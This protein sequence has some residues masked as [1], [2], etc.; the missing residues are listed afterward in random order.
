MREGRQ[1]LLG[2]KT[3]MLML[4]CFTAQAQVTGRLTDAAGRPVGFASVVLL[5]DADSTIVRSALSDEQGVFKL[6][7]DDGTYLLKISSLGCQPFRQPLDL[8]GLYDA[9]TI[10]LKAAEHQLGE[11][12]IR[13][14]KPLV[15]QQAGGLVV[16]VQNSLLTKGSTALEVLKRSPGV[17][18]DPQSTNITLN[19]KSG[20]MVMMDGKLL[21]L[22]LAQVMALLNG[23]NAD[24]I[25][26]IEL[27]N[28]P[29][30]RYDADGNAGLINIV[31]R[32]NKKPGTSGSV[33][34]SAGY[35]R[36]EKGSA[37]ISLDHN[38]GKVK[39]HSSYSYNHDRSYGLLLASGTENV[40]IIGGPTTFTYHGEGK[41]LNNYHGFSGGLEIKPGAKTTIGTNVYYS[42]SRDQNNA[43]N[44]GNYALADSNLAF[45]SH[46]AVN[47]TS[48]YLYGSMYLEHA[49]HKD[50]KLNIDVD[51]INRQ[52]SS[53]TQVE[54]NF[55]DSL[56]APR[57]RN[58]ANTDIRVGVIRIDQTDQLSKHLRL[59]AGVKGTYTKS[60]SNSGIENLVNGHW[61]YVGTGTSNN[62]GTNEFIAAAY[63]ILNV[64]LD[65]LTNLSAGGRYEHSQNTTDHSLNSQYAVNRRLGRFF[66]SVFVTRKFK[67][68]HEL[69]LSFTERIARPSYA[70]LAS[71]ITYNDPVSVFTGNPALKPTVTYNLKLGYSVN[72]LLFS[73][74]ASRDKD[75]ILGTQIMTGPT[76]GLV[77]LMPE[78]AE[79]QDN[80]T[81]QATIPVTVAGWWEMNYNF[82]GGWHQYRIGYFSTP[83]QKSYFSYSAELSENFRLPNKFAIEFSG[84]YNSSGY[85]GNS[86]YSGN[87]IFNAG[88]K[89]GE[90]TLSVSDIF[91]A[92]SYR[93][94]IGQLITDAFNTD[95]KVNYQAASHSFPVIK[96]SWSH[97]FGTGTKKPGH[98]NGTKEE[99][100]RL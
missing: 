48:H 14:S 34:A 10:V 57:Q 49:F 24:D 37:D 96:L 18:I 82:T 80:I 89:K 41:P 95:V 97:S 45:D 59:E 90:F 1:F 83:L 84:Y 61:E 67:N 72:E 100:G 23:M 17:I 9:G 65:S 74:L 76:K 44:Y 63:T 2:M 21:R 68:G 86:R 28:T 15:Q 3:L 19:G 79:R 42:L 33:T 29:P 98:Q 88:F 91:M 7:A 69:Q 30:A 22:P 43:H 93:S 58:L 56:F 71:Y 12:L 35:G 47:S 25:D 13:G 53:P 16:N 8:K 32:K 78:N 55:T 70:D 40:A 51:Y 31:T 11:V 52:N 85:S 38:T 54:S 6:M 87:A 64:Q 66:P 99:Q 5:K 81:L 92:A 50:H 20:V 94:S 27:L 39:F 75:P 62:L 60:I 26:K 77:Y 46:I 4:F 73:I 36:G